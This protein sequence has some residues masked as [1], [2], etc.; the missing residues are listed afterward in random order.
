MVRFVLASY[1]YNDFGN[2]GACVFNVQDP[3]KQNIYRASSSLLGHGV[4]FC[5]CLFHAANARPSILYRG[6][7]CGDT[8]FRDKE[9]RRN[10]LFRRNKR[11]DN[12][13]GEGTCFDIKDLY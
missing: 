8:L 6:V 2:F 3:Q 11:S 1:M 9:K 12:Y 10:I 4:F 13:V 5:Y 7:P